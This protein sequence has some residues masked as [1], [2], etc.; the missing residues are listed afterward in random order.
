MRVSEID[1]MTSSGEKKPNYSRRFMW[2]AGCIVAAGLAYTAA[3]FYAAD[4]LEARVNAS[5]AGINGNGKRASCENAEVRGYP[6]RIG[7]FCKSVMYVD[8]RAGFGLR[9]R[10]FRSAAQVY[11]PNRIVWEMDGPATLEV[12]GL[13]ALDLDW[14]SLRASSR[15]ASSKPRLISV[16]AQNINFRLSEADSSSPALGT[17]GNGQFHMRPVGE[18]VDLAF[19]FTDLKLDGD[20]VGAGEMP[21]LSGLVDVNLRQGLAALKDGNGLRGKSGEIRNLTA[22]FGEETGATIS[23]PVSVDDFGLIDAQLQVTIRK[24][25]LL[26]AILADAFP[27]LRDEIQ[28]SFSS[29]AA[30]GENPTLPVRV[31]RGEIQLG[32]LTIGSIPPL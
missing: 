6:F 4:R 15:L 13:N 8:A 22:S 14:G 20:V 7:V 24:P 32:F 9:A 21:A 23:G 30:M 25:E 11:D 16:E 27:D 10:Q 12:P 29:I 1:G 18:D 31:E 3:W 26:A 19:R 5:V 2:F 17:I 28:L